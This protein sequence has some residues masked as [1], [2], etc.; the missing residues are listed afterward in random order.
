MHY[1]IHKYQVKIIIKINFF[2]I[3]KFV[4][5]FLVIQ[6]ETKEDLI[7]PQY[8]NDLRPSF[9]PVEYDFPPEEKGFV[10]EI[11]N[12][13]QINQLTNPIYKFLNEDSIYD[14]ISTNLTN[15]VCYFK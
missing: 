12:G 7:T 3:F 1:P 11:T 2:L 9:N 8:E 5:V 15:E 13:L 14:A 4:L 10:L 6:I